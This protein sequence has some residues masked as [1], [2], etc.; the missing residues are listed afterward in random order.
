MKHN[1]RAMFE[2][3]LA[4]GDIIQCPACGEYNAYAQFDCN[5][6]PNTGV[7]LTNDDGY[8][9]GNEPYTDNDILTTWPDVYH[10]PSAS[11]YEWQCGS[12]KLSFAPVDSPIMAECYTHVDYGNL[13]FSE[14]E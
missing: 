14:E 10:I 1:S 6:D 3:L 13:A 8:S 4:K 7:R 9:D 2:K 5:I 12:C 11:C